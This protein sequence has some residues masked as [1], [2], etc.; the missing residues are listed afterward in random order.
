M[1]LID[2]LRTLGTKIERMREHV[3]TEEGT[4]N[5][6][7]LPFISA[8]GYDIFD[9]TEV[10]AESI[11]DVGIKKGEKV[12]YAILQNGQ[13]IMLFE[14]KMLGAKL[15]TE[16]ASQLFRYFTT[17][18]TRVG[19][20]TNGQQYRFFSDLDEPNKMDAKPFLEFDL[21]SINENTAASIK[22]FHKTFFDVQHIST[23]SMELKYSKEIKRILH[24]MLSEPSEDF[25]RF[26][27]RQ[28]HNGSVGQKVLDQF[29][30]LCKIAFGQYVTERINTR[31]TSAMEAEVPLPAP[32]PAP[33]V[34]PVEAGTE[35]VVTSL[36][37]IEGTGIVTKILVENG[38]DPARITMRDQQSY[39]GILLDDN[40]RRPI[41][42]LY[43][44]NMERLQIGWF[45]GDRQEVKETLQAVADVQNYAEKFKA[46]VEMYDK[47]FPPV[48]KVEK[49]LSA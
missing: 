41:C 8:L 15:D 18:P 37:E 44:N 11:A 32:V 1:D 34:P 39:C 20:L 19:I 12:D 45:N 42:R 5:A 43:F 21:M 30:R 46:T 4:K 14:C 36:Q 48:K 2:Q 47:Q 10:C 31:L 13:P 27:A 3:K 6:F 7:I 16:H 25:V 24:D 9:P 28:I 33:I 40:N 38:I 26:F 49:A 35:A 23:T 29:T 22:L 17:T